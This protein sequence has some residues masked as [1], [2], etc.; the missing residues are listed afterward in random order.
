MMIRFSPATEFGAGSDV[1]E[2]GKYPAGRREG[3][4]SERLPPVPA[5]LAQAGLFMTVK[6]IGSRIYS[7]R[8]A[9]ASLEIGKLA[10]AAFDVFAVGFLAAFA[11]LLGVS[12]AGA[13]FIL[14][15]SVFG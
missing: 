1:Q 15:L 10:Q 4:F 12:I 7:L 8:P 3:R 5:G 13:F 2:A 9:C 14:V 11:S 6:A